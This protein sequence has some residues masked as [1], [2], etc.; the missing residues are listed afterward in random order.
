M[1][2]LLIEDDNMVG[3][4]LRTALAASG[5]AV[6]WVRDG[7]A[8]ELALA[9]ADHDLVL[10]DLGLPVK[11]GLQ[12]LRQLRAR[13]GRV[14][15]LVIS[16]RDSVPDRVLG[17][18]AG[19]DDYLL[20]P[21][22]LDELVARVHA[23]ARRSA[24]AAA[25]IFQCGGLSLDPA[26]MRVAIDGLVVELTAREFALLEALVRR[27]GAVISRRRLEDCVYGW[28]EEVASNTVEVH[29]H[30]LRRK[31]GADRIVNVRGLG[32]RLASL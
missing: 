18:N 30:H 4:A 6:D 3:R 23:L 32:Y 10:L 12:L 7:R 17:L 5:F 25:P 24:G 1:R 31:L 27:P 22:E 8:G 11:D 15:V 16:A 26:R 9:N 28:G 21:F 2:L 19:A 13:G 14:P 29:L 20:K